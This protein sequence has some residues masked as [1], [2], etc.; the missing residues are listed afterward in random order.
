MVHEVKAGAKGP[1]RMGVDAKSLIPD[2]YLP[3][4][5]DPTNV[6]KKWSYQA[7]SYLGLAVD[8]SLPALL[9]NSENLKEE[10]SAEKATT[11]G[12]KDSWDPQLRAFL[13][14]KT[15]GDAFTTVRSGEAK[16]ALEL[17]RQLAESADPQTEGR[18]MHD[19]EALLGW[20]RCNDLHR[21]RAYAQEWEDAA[22]AYE[23]RSGEKI[24]VTFWRVGLLKILPQSLYNE[25][26]H[27]KGNFPTYAAL[28]SHVRVMVAEREYGHKSKGWEARLQSCEE[29][30]QEG[31]GADGDDYGLDAALDDAQDKLARGEMGQNELLAIIQGARQKGK[32]K[33]KGGSGRG[34]AQKG[35]G[36][37]L[38]GSNRDTRECYACGR[39]GHTR[40]QCRSTLHKDGGPIRPKPSYAGN[41]AEADKRD[42]GSLE[43]L[44]PGGHGSGFDLCACE[45]KDRFSPEVQQEIDEIVTTFGELLD[46][47]DE[48]NDDEE[49][50]HELN[51]VDD[52]DPLQSADAWELALRRAGRKAGKGRNRGA[53][54]QDVFVHRNRFGVLDEGDERGGPSVQH[55]T[56]SGI[57]SEVPPSETPT[58]VHLLAPG[59]GPLGNNSA[60]WNQEEDPDA[61]IRDALQS[62]EDT[63]RLVAN[64]GKTGH[65]NMQANRQGDQNQV[66]TNYWVR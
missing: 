9:K 15:A 39:I 12:M 58:M 22:L 14:A 20:T 3:S 48:E 59:K 55:G 6:W 29:S 47:S 10:V 46:E 5:D 50:E 33:G 17:W 28:K 56:Q 49:G 1:P 36:K 32:G 57:H 4:T 18:Q 27:I 38:F 41:A 16:P 54:K 63:A 23:D 34:G 51:A 64:I 25:L 37:Q 21:L 61:Q 52:E 2:S 66:D 44:E 53:A 26:R 7:R 8:P 42:T 35:G 31:P 43:A 62:L 13:N 30:A 11:L 24:P 19:L 40:A 65:E 45:Q 60:R